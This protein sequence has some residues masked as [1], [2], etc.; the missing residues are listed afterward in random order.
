MIHHQRCGFLMAKS[1]EN[2][3]ENMGKQED[4]W[5]TQKLNYKWMV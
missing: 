1:W 5:E 2:I 3:W 4:I